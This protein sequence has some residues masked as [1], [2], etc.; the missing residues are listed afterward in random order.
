M[1]A[2]DLGHVAWLGPGR[3]VLGVAFNVGLEERIY[4]RFFSVVALLYQL[5]PQAPAGARL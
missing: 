4:A 2:W 3:G 5:I 1:K